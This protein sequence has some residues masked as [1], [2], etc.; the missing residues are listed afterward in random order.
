MNS[1]KRIIRLIEHYI[2]D[3]KGDAVQEVY[4]SGTKVRI[5]NM[6]FAYST[7][8]VLLEVVIVLGDV[9]NED[10]LDRT[11]VDILV[12]DALVLFFPDHSVK[13]IVSWDS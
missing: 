12:Q 3:F 8:S 11:L 7:D 5:H 6:T 13:T 2:N 4:G 1:K 9:I 10:V